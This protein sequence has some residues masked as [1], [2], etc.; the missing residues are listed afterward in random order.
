[1]SLEALEALDADNLRLGSQ[2]Y[3]H[4]AILAAA[5]SRTSSGGWQGRWTR[6][7]D[8]QADTREFTSRSLDLAL[9]EGIGFLTSSDGIDTSYRMAAMGRRKPKRW[10]MSVPCVLPPTMRRC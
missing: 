10:F 8:D 3:Q 5:L 1:M 9:Q 2:R 6:I 7:A 4:D